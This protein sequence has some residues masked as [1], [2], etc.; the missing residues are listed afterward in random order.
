MLSQYNDKKGATNRFGVHYLIIFVILPLLFG[1]GVYILF[2]SPPD[3][4]EG[5]YFWEPPLVSLKKLPDYCSSFIKFHLAD[6]CWSFSLSAALF[7]WISDLLLSCLFAAGCLLLFELFQALGA[8]RG[9]GDLWD[10]LFSLSAIFIFY[11][12]IKRRSKNAKEK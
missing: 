2:K 10:I 1:A 4:F 7:F 6:M 8:I 12:F 5:L 11:L 3:L 9:K